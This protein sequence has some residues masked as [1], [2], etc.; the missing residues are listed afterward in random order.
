MLSESF[1]PDELELDSP[2]PEIEAMMHKQY[3]NGFGNCDNSLSCHTD[4]G[5][6]FDYPETSPKSRIVKFSTEES[7]E[8]CFELFRASIEHKFIT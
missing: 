6:L 4:S 8:S 7:G 2:R 5:L 1:F 3:V